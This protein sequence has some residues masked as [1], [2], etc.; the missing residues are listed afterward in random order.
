MIRSQTTLLETS[1][2]AIG[3]PKQLKAPLFENLNLSLRKG[4]VT[5][6]MGPNGAGKST[7]IKTLTG[8]L[9][10]IE[11]RISYEGNTSLLKYPQQ[12]AKVFAVVLTGNSTFGILRA[13]EVVAIG[14]HPHTKW[15][16]RYTA[17]D[18]EKVE[19]ALEAVNAKELSER[20]VHTL[21]DGERQRVMIARALAQETPIIYL[22]EPTAYLDLPNRV[23]LMQIL[24][25]LARDCGLTLLI[26]THELELALQHADQLWL[27]GRQGSFVS[28]LPED[29]LLDGQLERV[30]STGNLNFDRSRGVFHSAVKVHGHVCLK[31]ESVG[32]KWTR[33]ALEKLGVGV[34][35][36]DDAVLQ[37][38]IKSSTP[39]D[40]A[41]YGWSAI[42][43]VSGESDEGN[44]IQ[45]LLHWI[46]LR[47]ESE[48]FH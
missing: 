48:L 8:L 21:S 11:G 13:S 7:L 16:G 39:H 6:L 43:R 3:Y 20:W 5:C 47:W 22:D 12:R 1:A 36:S 23:E 15:T 31:G 37:I 29:L 34:S 18:Q 42:H 33:N 46:R 41:S 14:R 44:D 30:F 26:S 32:V 27:M 35:E 10:P 17:Q 25:K 28:G 40:K 38:V 2:L 4:T 19:W 9:P 24:R 45:S